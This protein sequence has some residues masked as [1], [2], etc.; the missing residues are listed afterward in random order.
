MTSYS[1]TNNILIKNKEATFEESE[2]KSQSQKEAKRINKVLNKRV[3]GNYVYII[4]LLLEYDKEVLKKL[5]EKINNDENI[6]SNADLLTKVK[7]Y[8]NEISNSIPN[9]REKIKTSFKSLYSFGLGFGNDDGEKSLKSEFNVNDD[10]ANFA[11]VGDDFIMNQESVDK[12]KNRQLRDEEID[13]Q[14]EKYLLQKGQRTKKQLNNDRSERLNNIAENYIDNR[15]SYLI[16]KTLSEEIDTLKNNIGDYIKNRSIELENN[17]NKISD[18]NIDDLIENLSKKLDLNRKIEYFSGGEKKQIARTQVANK[19]KSLESILEKMKRGDNFNDLSEKNK[20]KVKKSI[21]FQGDWNQ[22]EKDGRRSTI[23]KALVRQKELQNESVSKKNKS[24]ERRIV[25]EL[26]AAYNLGRLK[27]Y[28]DNGISHV[29]WNL[30]RE[31]LARDV[32]CEFCFTRANGGYRANGIYRIREDIFT[33]EEVQIPV[34]PYCGCYYTPVKVEQNENL[35][36]GKGKITQISSAG[37]TIVETKSGELEEDQIAKSFFPHDINGTNIANVALGIGALYM[38]LSRSKGTK[39]Q[40]TKNIIDEPNT[41][42]GAIKGLNQYEQ[43]LRILERTERRDTSLN[44]ELADE[45]NQLRIINEEEQ[46]PL[47]QLDKPVILQQVETLLNNPENQE[48]LEENLQLDLIEIQAREGVSIKRNNGDSKTRDKNEERIKSTDEL[49]E[50]QIRQEAV[51]DE[52]ISPIERISNEKA[53]IES[54]VDLER[55]MKKDIESESIYNQIDDIQNDINQVNLSNYS[56]IEEWKNAVL[57]AIENSNEAEAKRIINEALKIKDDIFNI[58]NSAESRISNEINSSLSNIKNKIVD[59]SIDNNQILTY[60]DINSSNDMKKLYKRIDNLI[61]QTKQLRQLENELNKFTISKYTLKNEDFR[62]NLK[63]YFDVSEVT[64][65]SKAADDEISRINKETKSFKASLESFKKSFNDVIQS[66]SENRPNL[67]K[68]FREKRNRLRRRK[69]ENDRSKIFY[70][71]KNDQVSKLDIE[72]KRL[73]DLN[74]RLISLEL[75][76]QMTSSSKKLKK[77]VESKL[78]ELKQI[79]SDFYKINARYNNLEKIEKID[80]ILSKNRKNGLLDMKKFEENL[81]E[82]LDKAE[83]AYK[84]GRRKEAKKF[85]KNAQDLV[86]RRENLRMDIENQIEFIQ[87]RLKNESQDQFASRIEKRIYSQ[88]LKELKELED[89]FNSRDYQKIKLDYDEDSLTSFSLKAKM[90][91]D[92][93]ASFNKFMYNKIPKRYKTYNKK[94]KKQFPNRTFI[95]NKMRKIENKSKDNILKRLGKI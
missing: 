40:K 53:E 30:E 61:E 24:I 43:L 4:N 36:E 55:G 44:D 66:S 2:D 3:R 88:K 92:N 46:Q 67:R 80:N 56:S 37:M 52:T 91:T 94:L 21:I 39:R 76:D 50:N 68:K 65:V 35:K 63:E 11:V 49:K 27:A 12:I 16:E 42:V 47:P 60:Q 8:T 6:K 82:N 51:G 10:L 59:R 93:I 87:N 9:S 38:L 90:I 14:I 28:L 18:K 73:E 89:K 20:E 64:N 83:E 26:N 25:T 57:R 81:D 85:K 34:H 19:N 54:N 69:N 45:N 13:D 79:K 62:N 31:H 1:L 75:R 17:N 32:V 41:S 72:I 48:I 5:K 95:N 74:N 58:A 23:E 77:S 7:I 33:N 15:S 22:V 78:K 70:D 84:D 71:D 86:K 29:K